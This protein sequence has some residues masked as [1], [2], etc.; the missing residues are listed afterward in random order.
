MEYQ[1][2]KEQINQFKQSLSRVQSSDEALGL[3]N[4]LLKNFD[5]NLPGSRDYCLNE[6]N[7]LQKIYPRNGTSLERLTKLL[8]ILIEQVVEKKWYEG[9]KMFNTPEDVYRDPSLFE[10]H[11][12]SKEISPLF[13]YIKLVEHWVTRIPNSI[14]RR[15]RRVINHPGGNTMGLM[16]SKA[17]L[18][19]LSFLNQLA[20]ECESQTNL[21]GKRAIWVTSILRTAEHQ[22]HLAK[23]GYYAPRGTS[24]IHGYSADIEQGWVKNHSKK[25][26]HIISRIIADYEEKGVINSIDYK[27]HWHI[28]LHPEYIKEFEERGQVYLT[29]PGRKKMESLCA[30]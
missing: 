30:E 11:S 22:D 7:Y 14:A 23:I 20:L 13:G 19:M 4:T 26:Y 25:N 28:C 21:P 2:V 12:W 29:R 15:I 10:F 18:G 17:P 24:H 8:P 6:L 27:N 3:F 9:Y 5:K 1:S 16:N